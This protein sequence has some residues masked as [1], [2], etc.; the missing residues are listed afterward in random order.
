MFPPLLEK[1]NRHRDLTTDEA[2]AAMTQIMEGHA[3]PAQIAGLL[4]GLG[5]KGERPGEIVGLARTM[6]AH[7]VKL[8]KRYVEVFDTCGTGGRPLEHLQRVVGRGGGGG[9]VRCARGQAREPLGLEP[10]WKR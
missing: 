5:M 2:A 1:L 7:S 8:A 10:V 4:I 3:T 9:G 6:R